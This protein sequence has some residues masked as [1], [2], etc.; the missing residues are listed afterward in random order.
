MATT[1]GPLT[2]VNSKSP[3]ILTPMNM[4]SPLRQPLLLPRFE[5]EEVY[6]P[7]P[8]D[9]PE[10]LAQTYTKTQNFVAK[11]KAIWNDMYLETLITQKSKHF[12]VAPPEFGK[13]DLVVFSSDKPHG[14]KYEIARVDRVR[15]KDEV[16]VEVDLAAGLGRPGP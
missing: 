12:V 10:T 6:S 9:S 14:P 1:A 5:L 2:I 8:H 13:G 3:I 16:P 15:T 7:S 4:L 11:V